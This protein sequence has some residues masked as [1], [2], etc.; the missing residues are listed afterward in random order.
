[1]HWRP[2]QSERSEGPVGSHPAEAWRNATRVINFDS[3]RQPWIRGF[4]ST[5]VTNEHQRC[6]S[7]TPQTTNS[8]GV[9][10]SG[11]H[12]LARLRIAEAN[13]VIIQLNDANPSAWGRTSYN[14]AASLVTGMIMIDAFYG[15]IASLDFPWLVCLFLGFYFPLF[16]QRKPKENKRKRRKPKENHRIHTAPNQRKPKE[17]ERNQMT[18]KEIKGYQRKNEIIQ[19]ELT[20]AVASS[21]VFLV[22]SFGFLPQLKAI[23]WCNPCVGRLTL[24]PFGPYLGG[25][26][27]HLLQK[28]HLYW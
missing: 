18:S 16:L 7:G 1:M 2:S 6:W 5:K 17:T 3:A 21:F 8:W 10:E 13:A 24:L 27:E 15:L 26:M 23:F 22:V 9:C 28:T 14:L 19:E 12:G 11:L 25:N 20:L 4:T